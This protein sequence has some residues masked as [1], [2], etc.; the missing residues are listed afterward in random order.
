MAISLD[1]TEITIL[2]AIGFGGGD[3]KG[4]ALIERAAGLDERELIDAL[5]GLVDV[6]F[7]IA[8]TSS[9][10]NLEDVQ[11][12]TY[13]VNSGYTKELKE[14]MDPSEAERKPKRVRRE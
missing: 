12:A 14:A 1:G 9:F 3:T 11:R 13:T 5:K 4:E 2:K 8:D 10:K 6:G 7:V